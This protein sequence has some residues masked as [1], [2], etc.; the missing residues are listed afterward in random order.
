MDTTKYSEILRLSLQQSS[1]EN[2]SSS[3]E[4]FPIPSTPTPISYKTERMYIIS[5]LNY[6]TEKIKQLSK[7]IEKLYEIN[8]N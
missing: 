1:S 5:N 3:D 4:E 8:N 6:L 7:D 2:E